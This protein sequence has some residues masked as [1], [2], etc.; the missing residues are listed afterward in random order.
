MFSQMTQ[1][2]KAMD[3]QLE[4]ICSPCCVDC[5]FTSIPWMPYNSNI[6][7]QNKMLHRLEG[8]KASD[9]MERDLPAI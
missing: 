3:K 8:M 5:S 7:A 6:Q 9:G 2:C 4:H 1:S